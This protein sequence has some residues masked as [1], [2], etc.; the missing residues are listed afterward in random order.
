MDD[1]ICA[2]ATPAGEGGIGIVRVSGDRAILLTGGVIR[3]RSG[4]PLS[5][6]RSFFLHHADVL[7]APQSHTQEGHTPTPASAL[8]EALVAVMRGPRSY[9]GEDVVEIHCHGGPFVLQRLCESLARLGARLA[10]PGEFTKRAFLHGRLDLTQAEAVLDTIRARTSSSLRLAQAQLR[11]QLAHE[12]EFFRD[13]VAGWLARVEAGIDFVDED[14][15]FIQPDQLVAGLQALIARIAGLVGTGRDGRILR[16]GVHAAIIGRPNVGKSSLLNAFLR[17]DRAIV[18]PIPG[19]TRDVI[20]EVVSIDGVAF[21]LVDTAG[22]RNTEDP[23]EQEGV[24][25]SHATMEDADILIVV[26]DAT[27]SLTDEDRRLCAAYPEKRRLFVINKSDLHATLTAEDCSPLGPEGPRIG[28][29]TPTLLVSAKYGSGL[30]ELRHR[31]RGL[32]VRAGLEPGETAL[33]TSLRHQNALDRAQQALTNALYSVTARMAGECV[34]MDLR[35][36]LDA[37]GEITGAVTTDDI[38]N[39]I[40]SEFCIGK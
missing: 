6:A 16:E 11:G 35:A 12:V 24:R 4:K 22:I 36:A 38:L 14:L 32:A 26:L 7:E 37:L 30:D 34:A 2:V 20:E 8:D 13:Q 31:L 19:T 1:T 17:T 40:F 39:R 10:E 23:I 29:A 9:T 33:V 15:E 28:E 25:R 27:S 5:S 21:R 18:T 3:L